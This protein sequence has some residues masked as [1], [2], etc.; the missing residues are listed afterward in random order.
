MEI[1]H[2]S[3]LDYSKRV[4]ASCPPARRTIVCRNTRHFVQL[5]HLLFH[6][7]I[8]PWDG[9]LA[10]GRLKVAAALTARPN[11]TDALFDTQLPVDDH[12]VCLGRH[13]TGDTADEIVK[14]AI[15][16]FWSSRFKWSLFDGRPKPKA[17]LIDLRPIGLSPVLMTYAE[18]IK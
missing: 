3:T 17:G 6:A 1:I 7:S 9:R 15:Q 18:F 16:R 8:Y 4:V 2:R 10:L 13:V 11:P 14:N 12:E 5:P